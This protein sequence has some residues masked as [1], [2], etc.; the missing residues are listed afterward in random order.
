MSDKMCQSFLQENY[1]YLK[2]VVKAYM[3]VTVWMDEILYALF[4]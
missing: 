2:A 1:A 3:T 4:H